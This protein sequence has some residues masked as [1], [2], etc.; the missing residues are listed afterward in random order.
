MDPRDLR[1]CEESLVHPDQEERMEPT[2]RKVPQV[3]PEQRVSPESQVCLYNIAVCS[4][5][6]T[7][8]S[9]SL[10]SLPPGKKGEDG[11]RG[12]PG[13]RGAS[14]VPGEDGPI[15]PPGPSGFPGDRGLSGPPGEP[16]DSGPQGEKGSRGQP[17]AAGSRGKRH[18][19]NRY[20][21]KF[22]SHIA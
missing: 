11:F 3:P 9:D 10:S 13:E 20:V 1:D 6:Y 12:E 8:I 4:I 17:G 19:L 21:S 5:F 2:A 14:G 7:R 18:G 16:G 15:G 22:Y